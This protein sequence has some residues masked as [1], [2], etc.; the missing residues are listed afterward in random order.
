MYV[1]LTLKSL[2]TF[3]VFIYLLYV[4]VMMVQNRPLPQWISSLVEHPIGRLLF[5]VVIVFFGVTTD[6][7]VFN[8]KML[9]TVL[10]FKLIAVLVTLSY[11]LTLLHC[12]NKMMTERFND[13]EMTKLLNF[14]KIGKED[15]KV[16]DSKLL[17]HQYETSFNPKPYRDDEPLIGISDQEIPP[18]GMN[19]MSQPSGAYTD[20]GTSYA[21][22]MN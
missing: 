4:S 21:I 15:D 12:N 11:L 2:F 17:Q 20:S 9:N 7:E 10:N 5:V 6:I 1:E 13:I 3:A 18:D 14:K 22:G 16:T 19:F 8:N